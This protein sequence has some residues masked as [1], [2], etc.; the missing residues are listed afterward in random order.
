M[1]IAPLTSFP[2]RKL[3][4]NTYL[5]LEIIMCIEYKD[6]LQYLFDVN[7]QTRQFLFRNL[8]SIKNSYDNEGLIT[9]NIFDRFK[10]YQLLEKLYF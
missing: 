8:I 4:Y 5:T 9:H 1:E 6:A 2:F 10:D 7:K 3:R